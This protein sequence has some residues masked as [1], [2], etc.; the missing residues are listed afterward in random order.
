VQHFEVDS[1]SLSKVLINSDVVFTS[2]AGFDIPHN[3]D[4]ALFLTFTN[5]ENLFFVFFAF[6]FRRQ[7][8]PSVFVV[9]DT[10]AFDIVENLCNHPGV[11]WVDL[12]CTFSRPLAIISASLVELQ[13]NCSLPELTVRAPKLAKLEVVQE[14]PRFVAEKFVVEADHLVEASFKSTINEDITHNKFAPEDTAPTWFHFAIHAQSIEKMTMTGNEAQLEN[15]II[16]VSGAVGTLSLHSVTIGYLLLNAARVES[17]TITES[18]ITRLPHA[19]TSL[20]TLKKAGKLGSL[21]AKRVFTRDS[22][23]AL[24]EATILL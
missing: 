8:I 5:G 6:N 18:I 12:M 19:L 13:I 24:T 15:L 3:E 1:P 17:I 7:I 9:E 21:Q 11:T 16:N 2:F 4:M 14:S 23:K 10:R 22:F 20:Q